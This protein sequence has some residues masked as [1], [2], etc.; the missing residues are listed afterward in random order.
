MNTLK[1]VQNLTPF[2]GFILSF[3]CGLLIITILQKEVSAD[4][5]SL[6][7]IDQGLLTIKADN[8]ELKH[9]ILEFEAQHS[10]MFTGFSDFM[11]NKI[12]LSYT[13]SKMD[14]IAKLLKLLEI[15]S[16]TYEFYGEQLIHVTAVPTSPKIN[17]SLGTVTE[18]TKKL[19]TNKLNSSTVQIQKVLPDSQGEMVQLEV[20]DY[21]I[22]YNG[23]KIPNARRLIDYVKKYKLEAFVSIV[24]VRDERILEFTLG[25][26]MIGVQ[27]T[28]IPIKFEIL[29]D[30]Y[31]D[32]GI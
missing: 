27:I 30:Y 7:V 11:E 24:I 12:T 1:N 26:G 13:G 22:A 2:L 25:G 14:I 8:L 29:E 6:S 5:S 31:R 18:T 10:L 32:L 23:H 16:Y 20:N 15:Q 4:S 19:D 17:N 28:T 21:I 9:I 3:L